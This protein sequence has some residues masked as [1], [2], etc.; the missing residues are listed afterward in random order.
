MSE[1]NKK[2][3]QKALELLSKRSYSKSILADKLRLKDFEEKEIA[4]AMKRLEY[5][6]FI[7]DRKYAENL[8]RE[9]STYK[10]YGAQRIKFKLKEKKISDDIIVEILAGI[11]ERIESEN[12]D[13]LTKRYLSK[14]RSIPKEKQYNRTL[15]YLIRRGYSFDA[16]KKAFYKISQNI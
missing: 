4:Q 6:G 9:Y 7:D 1:Q 11:D 2:A 10:K 3:L 15:G 16:A 12:L 8:A 13:E 14:I 5:L